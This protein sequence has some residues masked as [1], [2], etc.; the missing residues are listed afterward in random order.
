MDRAGRPPD[1]M[2][3]ANG[4]GSAAVRVPTH[5]FAGRLDLPPGALDGVGAQAAA[6]GML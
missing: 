1:R 2:S 4:P 6:A 5:R 3:V